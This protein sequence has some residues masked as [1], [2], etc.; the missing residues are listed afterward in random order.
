MKIIVKSYTDIADNVRRIDAA[1]KEIR[2]SGLKQE[3]IVTL[4]H[5]KT[6]VNKGEI[7]RV[8]EGLQT[9]GKDNLK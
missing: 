1:M 3:T 7:R 5:A 9:F 2:N 8:I 4:L 6:K